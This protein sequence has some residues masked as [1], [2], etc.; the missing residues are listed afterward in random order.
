MT[1]LRISQLAARTGFSATTLRY[2]EEVGLVRPTER[3]ASGYRMY[4]ERAVE[5]LAFVARAKGLGLSLDEIVELAHL[6]DTDRCEP[7]Q[8]RLRALLAAKRHEAQD[9]IAALV[10]F[11]A[12]LD[13]VSH[14]LGVPAPDGPCDATCGCLS[15]DG[16]AGAAPAPVRLMATRSWPIDDG[17]SAPVACTLGAA[18][19]PARL[20]DWR[21]L[22][23]DATDRA[24]TA[25]GVRVT[26]PATPGLA[27]R[28]AELARAEQDC[29]R[30]FGFTLHI[31]AELIEL[32][33]TA[34]PEGRDV[35]FALF[36]AAS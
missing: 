24:A 25:E 27:G 13:E 28:V 4:D 19:V 23:A 11:A 5:R 6:R 31:G 9:R 14:G 33:I 26:F 32:D 8:E 17:S 18:D 16:P 20:A 36:G 10:R 34:P 21:R 7:V 22:L 30:F 2:Y 12:E 1:A 15:E 3:T 29:C 35:V